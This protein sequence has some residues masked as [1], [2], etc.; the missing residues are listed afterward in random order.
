M[1]DAVAPL[2]LTSAVGGSEYSASRS[3][4]CSPDNP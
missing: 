1:G 4:R 2:I 3:G